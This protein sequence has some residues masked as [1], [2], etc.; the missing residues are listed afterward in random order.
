MFAWGQ[1]MIQIQ[2]CAVTEQKYNPFNSSTLSFVM[3]FLGRLFIKTEAKTYF[4]IVALISFTLFFQFATSLSTQIAK[5]L[6]I[7]V[8]TIKS[9]SEKT[10]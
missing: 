10:K 9:N 2:L 8:F 3:L 5:I 7:K 6:N 4:T 1:N